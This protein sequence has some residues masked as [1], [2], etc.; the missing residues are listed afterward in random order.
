MPVLLPRNPS[1]F[2]G[3]GVDRKG[4]SGG[5]RAYL[6]QQKSDSRSCTGLPIVGVSTF[7]FIDLHLMISSTSLSA[8]QSLLEMFSSIV[9]I[10]LTWSKG[11]WKYCMDNQ[12]HYS[13]GIPCNRSFPN[14]LWPHFQSESCFTV[15]IRD[16]VKRRANVFN[17]EQRTMKILYG[18]PIAIF[19]GDLSGCERFAFILI[20]YNF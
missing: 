20:V 5:D 14:Y 3:R 6:N 4:E 12:L 2:L 15:T 7:T 17:L 11:P 10:F 8:L 16:V 9:Q 19:N 1:L 13:I 18:Q